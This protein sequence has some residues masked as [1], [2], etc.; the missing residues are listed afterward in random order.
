MAASVLHPADN[1]GVGTG[2]VRRLGTV[3][4][5]R[6]WLIFLCVLL[7]GAGATAYMQYAPKQ[8]AATTTVEY[9]ASLMQYL[10]PNQGGPVDPDREIADVKR[11]LQST[12]LLSKVV[13]A[14]RLHENP[15]FRGGLS[16]QDAIDQALK[17]LR[18]RLTVEIPTDDQA[19]RITFKD[20]L[21]DLAVRVVNS[22]V[23]ELLEKYS[24]Q[25]SELFD[26]VGETL[27][28]RS[29]DIWRD[30]R[31]LQPVEVP[32]PDGVPG[33]V[34]QQRTALQDA[35]QTLT[36]QRVEAEVEV[37]RLQEQLR[38]AE[39]PFDNPESALQ[40]AFLA[41]QTPVSAARKVLLDR[42]L[43]LEQVA[44]RYREKHPR[45]LAAQDAVQQSRSAL[46]EAIQAATASLRQALESTRTKRDELQRQ[47]DAKLTEL[48]AIPTATPTPEQTAN[49]SSNEQEV[50][51]ELYRGNL[52]ALKE[53]QYGGP[54]I[55]SPLKH[56]PAVTAGL[57][58]PTPPRLLAYGFSAGFLVGLL[59]SL[60]FGYGDTSLKTV[61]DVEQTLDL[62]VLSVVPRLKDKDSE[63]AAAE[64]F[65]SLRT[66]IAVSSREK[67]PRLVQFTSTSP[68]EG[69]TFCAL[70]F[71]VG[72]AQQGHRTVLVECDL[73]RPMAAPSL[74]LVNV[75][76]AGVSDYLKATSKAE[77][78]NAKAS[79]SGDTAGLSF[80]EIRKKKG[81][82]GKEGQKD[83][84]EGGSG[85]GGS[86]A[87]EDIVQRT[88][89]A[90]LFFVA[91]GKPVSSP[92][93]LLGRSRFED[94]LDSLL[95]RYDR[96]V[97]DSAPVLGVS[98]TLLIASRMHG[99]C[100]VVR[101]SQ[102]PRRAVIRA[103]EILR[104][105]DVPLL[106]AVLNGITPKKSDPYGQDYY[107]HRSADRG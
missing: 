94:M 11:T 77:T 99:V 21:A 76:A 88:E 8:Y 61:D 93:E 15:R 49:P 90:N 101:G 19:L 27:Q 89:V 1:R 68:D 69:K 25:R 96:V 33:A 48:S 39:Q 17:T 3:L 103:V 45:Y 84:L 104:R 14:E 31:A 28:L 9:Q 46:S 23:V 29:A 78:T 2:N 60:V 83:T 10:S 16:G 18:N 47:I 4:R 42:Q 51:L 85:G 97:L 52:A 87:L 13:V 44:E 5:E 36:T 67:E 74:T 107:Y 63:M 65:R 7:G 62:A 71:A 80:A 50:L 66:S 70:N 32:E 30:F 20:Q 79:A 55:L 22:L 34:Q 86:L 56:L 64:G 59:L 57:T 40:V 98:E 95:Q 72:L 102:T 53:L 81:E 35:L 106:G 58:G 6:A 91:A 100:F 73:R 92:T 38:A 26:Q 43:E 105:A 54:A 41:A 37:T 82:A 75:D 12:E 24:R